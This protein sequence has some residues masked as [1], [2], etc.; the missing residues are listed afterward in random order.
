MNIIRF[1][2]NNIVIRKTL[3]IFALIIFTLSPVSSGLTSIPISLT[4]LSL[5]VFIPIIA[6]HNKRKIICSG[7]MFLIFIIYIFLMKKI[8]IGVVLSWVGA[9]S[10]ESWLIIYFINGAM[11]G[12]LIFLPSVFET[13]YLKQAIEAILFDAI[14][15]GLLFSIFNFFFAM[16][17]IGVRLWSIL[18]GC[19]PF[20]E[21]KGKIMKT[22]YAV[23]RFMFCFIVGIYTFIYHSII[24]LWQKDLY[25]F[26]SG[27]LENTF[28]SIILFIVISF[29]T[30]ALFLRFTKYLNFI[31]P[32]GLRGVLNAVYLLPGL[33]FSV[34]LIALKLFLIF[35]GNFSGFGETGIEGD[36]LEGE[37]WSG[38]GIDIT[39]DGL[40]DGFDNNNDGMINTNI[41]GV[42]LGPLQSISSYVKS[43]GTFVNSYL[44]TTADGSLLNNL[45]PKI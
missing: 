21:S 32:E 15:V 33:I 11:F 34:G 24:T 35:G 28:M 13:M 7:L 12:L 31:L 9:Y 30:I 36:F 4:Y 8:V 1:I 38:E 26:S 2:L 23:G 20:L 43:D 45:R 18:F 40:I 17:Y 6:R 41:L 5:A 3:F 19:Y 39:G 29:F 14:L 44:R 27:G 22:V 10:I 16:F 37:N 25:S 42:E